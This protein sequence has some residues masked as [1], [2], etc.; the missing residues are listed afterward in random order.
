MPAA[1]ASQ[2]VGGDALV[3]QLALEHAPDRAARQLGRGTR[4]SAAARS[5]GSCVDAPAEQLLLGER[6]ALGQRRGDLQVVLGHARSAPRARPTS[7]SA[8]WPIRIALDLEARDVLAPAAQ[9]VGLAVDEVEVAVVV[10]PADVAGVVPPVAAGA[11]RWPRAGP[12]SPRTSRAGAWA[13]RRSRRRCPAATSL[14]SSSKM[15]TSKYSSLIDAGRVRP[16]V[17][18]RRLPRDQA[19]LGHAVRAAERVERR[20]ARG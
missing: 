14:S 18:A 15:R 8:P 19:G 10:D 9:V 11:R 17:D 16:V 5:T 3:A 12:S 20:T 1:S 13:A 4:C 6:R 2:V 7:A